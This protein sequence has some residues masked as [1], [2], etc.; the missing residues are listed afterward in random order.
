[1]TEIDKEIEAALFLSRS[2]GVGAALFKELIEK[3]KTPSIA[4]NY[5]QEKQLDKK[6]KLVSLTKNNTESSILKTLEAIKSKKI[7]AFY[8]GQ[9][10]YPKQLEAL[11][12]PPPIIY[13][14][15]EIKNKPFA[16]VVGSRNANEDQLKKAEK[17]TLKLIKDGYAIISGGAIGIDKVAHETAIRESAYTIAVLANGLDVVYPKSNKSLLE[18]IKNMGTLMTELMIGALPQKGFFP[19]RNR[20]IAALADIVI[21]LPTTNSK[22]TLITAQWAKKLGKKL[23]YE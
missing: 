9:T 13:L 23:I 20:L 10:G 12:E 1:M 7:L 14:S 11:T 22:G 6:L 21:A 3:Y 19:T 5:W 18:E 8:Y 16:A 4:L 15:S 2:K 17:L